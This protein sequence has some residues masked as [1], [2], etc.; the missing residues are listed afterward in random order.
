VVADPSHRHEPFPLTDLQRAYIVGRN[1][2][3]ALG[4]IGCDVYLE[5]DRP[6][7]DPKRLEAVWNKLILRHEVL[8][9]VIADSDHQ[10]IL[11]E[12]P[13]FKIPVIDL[14]AAAPAEI[15]AALASVR[16]QMSRQ[17]Q[18]VHTWPLYDIRVALLPGGNARILV[19]FDLI[20][21][22]AA[23]LHRILRELAVAY[24]NSSKE[25]FSP[26][27]ISYRDYRLADERRRAGAG[28]ERDRQFWQG[29][30][31][32]LP[33]APQLPFAASLDELTPP[34]FSR[35]ERRFNAAATR[36]LEAAAS[37]YNLSLA[38]VLNA[39][40]A[41]VVAQWSAER[42]FLLNL[43]TFLPPD[44][45][46]FLDPTTGNYTSNVLVAADMRSGGFVMRARNFF[47]ALTLALQHRSYSG[48]RV[49]R[50]LHKLHGSP[51]QPV[52]P[53]APVV[54]TNMVGH[55]KMP[56]GGPQNFGK[57]VWGVSRTPQVL[58]DHQVLAHGQDLTFCWDSVAGAFPPGVIDAMADAHIR[59]LVRLAAGEEA[60][61]DPNLS[62][63]A[64]E[65]AAVRTRVNNTAREVPLRRLHE[66]FFAAAA[67][68][69][70]APAL[71]EGD[72]TV[73][74]GE[75]AARAAGAWRVLAAAGA[76]PGDAVACALPH[77]LDL[78]SVALGSLACGAVYAP[79]NPASPR[80]RRR[81]ELKVLKPKV[82]IDDGQTADPSSPFDCPVIV[83]SDIAPGD[84]Q[85]ASALA[86]TDGLGGD[87]DARAYV[88]FTS[89]TTGEPKAIAITHRGAANTCSDIVERFAIGRGDRVIGLSAPT[90]DLSIFDMFGLWSVGG[91]LV[92]P[93]PNRRSD[94]E[95]WTHAIET[96]GVTIWNTVPALV[97]MLAEHGESRQACFD[98]LRLV[99]LSGDW[100]APALIPRIARLAPRAETVSLGGATEAS[101]WSIIHPVKP[102]DARRASIPYGVPMRNQTIH[103]LD[104]A[105]VPRPDYVEGD[106]YIGGVGLAEC[107]V[108]DADKTASAF[109]VQPA[110]RQRLYRTGDRGRYAPDG[111][112][113]FLGRRDTQLKVHGFRIEAGEVEHVL[114]EADGA[115]QVIVEAVG[116]RFDSK[117]LVAFVVPAAGGAPADTDPNVIEQVR[118]LREQR[119]AFK[120]ERRGLRKLDAAARRVD[121]PE[122]PDNRPVKRRSARRFAAP[123]ASFDDLAF[124]LS[125]LRCTEIG[126]GYKYLYPSAGGL[127]PVQTYLYVEPE[128]V[129][130]LEGGLY[131]VD[132]GGS[133]VTLSTEPIATVDLHA[134]NNRTLANAAAFTLMMF[135]HL[136]AIAPQY[137]PLARDFCLL[138]AG[139]VAQMLMEAAVK[140]GCELCPIGVMAVEP[141]VSKAS[142]QSDDIFLHALVGGVRS[143]LP[144]EA[145]ADA[146]A[147]AYSGA[148]SK[149]TE[150][151]RAQAARRL[152][153]YMHPQDII[154]L[155][156]LP[157]AA[158][159]K[160]DRA[161]LRR[162]AT[163]KIHDTAEAEGPRTDAERRLTEIAMRV[164]GLSTVDVN[165][166]FFALG[167][168]SVKLVAFSAVTE[169]EFGR[170]VELVNAFQYP[171]IRKLAAFLSAS[172][173][174]LAADLVISQ[175]RQRSLNRRHARQRSS[176]GEND[177]G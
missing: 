15:D 4:G 166:E 170:R 29:L 116:E 152:P 173:T 134:P 19:K 28:W 21:T 95:A 172:S 111:E 103:V 13:W 6:Q 177:D 159:G 110:T 37:E 171:T 106:I 117:R 143:D 132:P 39:A 20:G 88:M 81:A 12:V 40:F 138:E 63:L 125:H 148:G 112:V 163:A 121:M 83:A 176:N 68:H 92:L 157:L 27:L 46:F 118:K 44:D 10:R 36:R 51:L 85:D 167:A 65:Q 74:Y 11:P 64:P 161:A 25:D 126:S 90:F 84:P 1:S 105:L 122:S 24:E 62:L 107:Y 72:R 114:G 8:R 135:G 98:S 57:M 89:G 131:Y 35:A 149:L 102:D 22:D 18:D 41:E 150:R 162:L 153:P 87:L 48:V 61:T 5:F 73:S 147:E 168:D 140:T 66:G 94:P 129:T 164:L 91:C 113:E 136:P 9:I 75:L 17:V 76:S 3:I 174:P 160:V 130:G 42:H 79:L 123:P 142:L 38:A 32:T 145:E 55:R 78:A 137:G 16:E 99:M 165:R 26:P 141:I 93:P 108:G 70:E 2:A 7:L 49:L 33:A 54:L 23:S 119:R 69:P 97:T 71:I 115:A 109:I 82:L 60:W 59:L 158:T 175:A 53:V 50:D 133:L 104:G 156:K 30:L 56:D 155:D 43:P 100:I 154:V 96:Q 52:A 67:E 14:A 124:I 151:L 77:G 146:P 128:R 86:R 34:R 120:V 139:Y 101:I 144:D 47:Q 31:A 127:Y 45:S 80:E 58:L 169:R